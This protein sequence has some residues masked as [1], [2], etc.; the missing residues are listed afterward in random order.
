MLS[1]VRMKHPPV[2]TF[3]VYLHHEKIQLRIV[4][5]AKLGCVFSAHSSTHIGPEEHLAVLLFAAEE[6]RI[7]EQ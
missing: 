2:T 4:I 7:V 6:I 1:L 3:A 5:H